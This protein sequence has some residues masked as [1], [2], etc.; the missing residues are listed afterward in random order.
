MVQ[1]RDLS[2]EVCCRL[3]GPER[4]GKSLRDFQQQEV[5]T[6]PGTEGA[7]KGNGALRV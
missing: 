1:L 3:K 4:D 2:R 6:N 5:V 7:M